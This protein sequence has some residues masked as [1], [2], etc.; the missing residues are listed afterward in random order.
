MSA[1]E[2]AAPS[3]FIKNSVERDLAEGRHGGAVRTR[4]PPEPNGY[5]HIG[6]A[7]AICLD[8]GVAEVGESAELGERRFDATFV[9]LLGGGEADGPVA[10]AL[11]WAL[12]RQFRSQAAETQ[13]LLELE[14]AMPAGLR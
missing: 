9:A 11:R 12:Y 4:F 8:F 2:P 14:A 1:P 10:A 6:H 7:K 13:R 3:N 5:L